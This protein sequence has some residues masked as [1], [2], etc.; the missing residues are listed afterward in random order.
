MQQLLNQEPPAKQATNKIGQRH[1]RIAEHDLPKEEFSGRLIC[2]AAELQS[3]ICPWNRL[4]ETAVQPNPFFDPDF[5]IPAFLHFGNRNVSVLVIEA[6]PRVNEQAAPIVCGLF[7]VIR[8]KIY[9]VPLNGIE[10]WKHDLCFDCTPLI[11]R[12]CAAAT[13]EFVFHFIGDQLNTGLF[14]LNTIAGDGD[15]SRLLTENFFNHDR[16]VFHR[17]QFTR[18]CFKPMADANTF[19]NTQ[20]ATST[21]KDCQ[22]LRRKLEKLG[23]VQTDQ[24]EKFDP[25]WTDEFLAMESRGWKGQNKTALASNPVTDEF[26]H[27]M[28]QRMFANDKLAVSRTSLD[29]RPIAMSWD[30]RHAE[31]A[32]HFRIAFD[33]SLRDFS[34]GLILELDNIHRL[35]ASRTTFV[36]SCAEPNHS[37]INRVW[38]D[39]VPF[40]SL[41]VA[42]GKAFSRF[43]TAAMPLV[44]Q[45]KKLFRKG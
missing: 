12:D 32:A 3:L 19:I 18:A 40:Q 31:T 30:L 34:P 41:V 11:R 13:L 38:R 33:E 7:P 2:D 21:R 20:V 43:A 23:T 44:Q 29:N 8:K 15:F 39:R 9:G 25:S 4:M 37:M 26:F 45:T 27:D 1:F 22:R 6:P 24:I 17:D 10:I 36:D 42:T 28:T 35:H 14:S 5:L 16:S